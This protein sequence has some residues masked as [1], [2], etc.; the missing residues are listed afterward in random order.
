MIRANLA[1]VRWKGLGPN[2][3]LCNICMHVLR[4]IPIKKKLDVL[5]LQTPYSGA[6]VSEG[7]PLVD[8][9][10]WMILWK[11]FVMLRNNICILDSNQFL[12]DTS[13]V[14]T[15]AVRTNFEHWNVTWHIC[16]HVYVH[17]TTLSIYMLLNTYLD[18]YISIMQLC[19]FICYL[20]HIWT[21]I[22]ALCNFEHLYVT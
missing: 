19:A 1:V 10:L 2:T 5:T 13:L 22:C 8:P 16:G 12:R 9:R 3:H 21:C 11:V 14:H 4:R 6:L 18:M 20:R 15:Q 17:Y 7:A